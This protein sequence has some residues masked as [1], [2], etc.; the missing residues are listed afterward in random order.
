MMNG[1]QDLDKLAGDPQAFDTKLAALDGQRQDTKRRITA[2][3]DAAHRE[4]GDK[5]HY[6]G[7][8]R[9]WGMPAETALAAA[10]KARAQRA[11][12]LAELA[13]IAA[14]ITAMNEIYRTAPWTRFFPS[15]T[16]SNSHIHES[17]S[18]RTLHFDTRMSWAPE[19]SGKTEAQAVA[20]LDEALCSV[21]FPSA[22][23]ALHNY[24]SK[25]SQA[26]QAERA[27][28]KN[29]RA[30]AKAAK[31]LDAGTEQFKDGDDWWVTTVTGAKTVIRQAVENPYYY[32]NHWASD[33]AKFLEA[34]A[35]AERVLLDREARQPGTGATAAE[36]AKIR[37]N[38][39]RKAKRDS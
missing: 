11:P 8:R 28:A 32:P 16:K 36:I 26:E 31:T 18:C 9:V 6:Q 30:A 14:E 22:P 37:D 12:L 10:P 15:I 17:L 39:E 23:V 7:R 5:Q 2:A 25:R 13:G 19:L 4:A 34:A 21:C 33:S 20:D 24:V 27:A 29:D 1:T 35:A 38:A 3:E